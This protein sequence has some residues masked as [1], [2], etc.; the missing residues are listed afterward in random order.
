MI[1]YN[2]WQI[3]ESESESESNLSERISHESLYSLLICP[4]LRTFSKRLAITRYQIQQT[5][6]SE[7][8]RIMETITTSVNISALYH[9]RKLDHNS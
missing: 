7:H 3:N 9:H 4:L 2:M 8:P 6:T 1:M 5:I